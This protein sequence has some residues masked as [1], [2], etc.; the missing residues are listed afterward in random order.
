MNLYD[1]AKDLFNYLTVFRWRIAAGNRPALED[2]KREVLDLFQEQEVQV[3]RHPELRGGYEQIRYALAVFA[4]E[5][6]LYADWDYAS[7]WENHLL[8]RHF[9]DT[10]VGGDR[11]F[12]LREEVEITDPDV[13][14]VFYT[15][16][17]L[18]FRGRY[19]SDSEQLRR[20]RQQLLERCEA[21]AGL[22]DGPLFPQ[23]YAVT[24]ARRL[25]RLPAIYQWRHV[26][27]ALVL[28]AAFFLVLDRLVIWEVMSAPVADV[29][30]LAEEVLA[31]GPEATRPGNAPPPAALSQIPA[32]PPVDRDAE[33]AEAILS[34]PAPAGTAGAGDEE[35]A[36]PAPDPAEPAE[37]PE[38]T[39]DVEPVPAPET[40]PPAASSAGAIPESGYAI[41]IAAFYSRDQ[42]EALK[43][44]LAARGHDPYI[45]SEPHR[46]GERT[47]YFVRTGHFPRGT[48]DEARKAADRFAQKENMKVFVTNYP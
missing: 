6:F 46:D 31:M 22:S 25:R 45:V 3:R 14:A 35:A 28:I 1:I 12:S 41:Q 5:V 33:L 29:A 17:N 18:G 30:E 24:R 7:D 4:D 20:L 13:A 38:P 48:M 39:P 32:P 21:G 43:A 40:G 42:A 15:C 11:F 34:E 26:G 44:E 37:P 2:V 36:G 23:A 8:E 47:W 9:F 27:A 10:E 16:L 19:D